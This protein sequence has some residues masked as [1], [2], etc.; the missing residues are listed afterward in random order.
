[1]EKSLKILMI[2]SDR[3]LLESGSA[4]SERIK[5]YGALVKE[6]HIVLL[7]DSK[8]GLKNKQLL[9]NV[10]VYPTNSALNFLRPID[11]AKLGKK[12]M[13]DKKF[14]RGKS[15]ITTQDP[16]ECG[17]AGMQVKKKWGIPLELQLHA[18]IFSPYFSG[19]QNMVRKFFLKKVLRHA[20]GVRV[21]TEN[22]KSKI[23]NFTSASI[24]VLPIYV[25]RKKIED[26]HAVLDLHTR[27]GWRFI[28]LTVS[29]LAPEKNL[30]ATL[31]ILMNVRDRFPD[32]GLVIVGSGPEEM[33]LKNLAKQL[34]VE[35][36][37]TFV[38]WQ[39]NLA[40]YYKTADVFIQTSL[41]E[42]YGLSLVEAG[43]SGLPVV[44]TP[45]GIA[46]ELEHGK[47]AYIYPLGNVTPFANG[48]IDLI[49]NNHK[50]EN[51]KI[52]L[53]HTLE[54]KLFSKEKY[55]SE[56]KSSWEHIALRVC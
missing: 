38:G 13:S 34:G 23:S 21:V 32:T 1:M 14:V 22:L 52:N 37:V 51:L 40:S 43:L 31:K 7:S 33:N 17:W 55:L 18:D 11:A 3:K 39:E 19:F 42:G 46:T 15:V 35:N 54:S 4:V 24:R 48:I 6:L 41:F 45:V 44:T 56:L 20:D 8:H 53:K 12:I 10:W 47:N 28:M 5:E 9:S 36:N 49:E 50:R 26:A 30:S 2:S 27:F 29:R 25:D 16:F